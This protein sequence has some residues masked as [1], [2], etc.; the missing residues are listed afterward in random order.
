MKHS[1]PKTTLN[2]LGV[3]FGVDAFS[4]P[5]L[6]PEASKAVNFPASNPDS[7]P[8]TFLVPFS[9]W[10]GQIGRSPKTTAT[11]SRLLRR[12]FAHCNSS[13]RSIPGAEWLGYDC[14]AQVRRLTGCA[15]RLFWD[16]CE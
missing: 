6:L 1:N 15:L 11:Y 12:Y 7:S 3:P 14:T 10:M 5:V 13:P 9:R 8:A 2:L 4:P 16:F